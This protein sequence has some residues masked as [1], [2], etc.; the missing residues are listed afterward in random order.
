MITEFIQKLERG[1]RQ[2]YGV[3]INSVESGLA[4]D[5]LKTVLSAEKIPHTIFLPKVESPNNI[6]WVI[7]VIVLSDSLTAKFMRDVVRGKSRQVHATQRQG[8]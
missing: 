7:S 3:R 4:E 2:E 6:D 8:H 1:K 5:D